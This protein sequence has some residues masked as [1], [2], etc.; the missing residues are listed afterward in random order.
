MR[1]KDGMP[2]TLNCFIR[3]RT[4]TRDLTRIQHRNGLLA[5]IQRIAVRQQAI[6]AITAAGTVYR[7]G[8]AITKTFPQDASPGDMVGVDMGLQQILE[9]QT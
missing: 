9:L 7:S 2:P 1:S 6:G 8:D 3:G 5:E 4:I